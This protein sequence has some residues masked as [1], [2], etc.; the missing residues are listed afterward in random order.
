MFFF[1][2]FDVFFYLASNYG[3]ACF[4]LHFFLDGCG[5]N[6]ANSY[7]H[8]ACHCCLYIPNV[9]NIQCCTRSLPNEILQQM[10]SSRAH[11]HTSTHAERTLSSCPFHYKTNVCVCLC[12]YL[13]RFND[14]MY[15]YACASVLF[16]IFFSGFRRRRCFCCIAIYL[17][18]SLVRTYS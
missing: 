16:L 18:Y 10:S 15:V 13:F 11:T 17:P 12:V 14:D 6:I 1:S 7:D 4:L 3:R 5:L 2:K 9:T 8:L